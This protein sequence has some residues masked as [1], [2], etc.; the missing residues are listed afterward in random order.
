MCP[1]TLP[2]YELYSPNQRVEAAGTKVHLYKLWDAPASP[3]LTQM[4]TN[5]SLTLLSELSGKGLSL[6]ILD[7][8]T[9]CPFPLPNGQKAPAPHGHTS[10]TNHPPQLAPPSSRG[11]CGHCFQYKWSRG[12]SAWECWAVP[13]GFSILLPQLAPFQTHTH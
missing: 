3:W 4:E 5:P 12:S 11:S 7:R 1:S 6:F 13:T 8:I 10:C 9:P 2:P